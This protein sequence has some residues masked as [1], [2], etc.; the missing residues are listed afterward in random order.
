[1]SNKDLRRFM[2]ES[3]KERSIWWY[4]TPAGF[5]IFAAHT[6][7]SKIKQVTISWKTIRAA[8]ARKN[9]EGDD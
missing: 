4:E 3:K 8:L 5:E 9:K 1:M 2:H 7:P 6:L